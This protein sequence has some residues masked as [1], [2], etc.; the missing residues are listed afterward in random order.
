MDIYP[1]PR[2]EDMFTSLAGG[3]VFTKLDLAHA[4][5]QVV[6]DEELKVVTTINT[7]KGLYQSNRLPFRVASTPSMFQCI[8][9]NVVQGLSA[10]CAYIDNIL[11]SWKTVDEHLQN[12]E[13]V[14]TRLQESGLRLMQE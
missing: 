12:L 4:Y 3:T 6:L 9:D 14:L 10:V 1:L 5:Q 13:A 2:I 8:M 7:H 11:V